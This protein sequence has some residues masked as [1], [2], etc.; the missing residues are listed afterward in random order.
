MTQKA[1]PDAF[2]R[3]Y[4]QRRIVKWGECD[5]FGIVY[6]P[7]ILD[8]A[9]EAAEGW[10]RDVVGVPWSALNAERRMGSPT[11]H[12]AI[13]FLRPVVC[14]QSLALKLRVTEL[15]RST[16]VFQIAGD[17][18]ASAAVSH[19]RV[20]LK[21]CLIDLTRLRPVAM[22]DDFRARILAFH[23]RRPPRR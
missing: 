20:R 15:G 7:R 11:V 9:L 23:G 17:S 18:G 6:T 22:P 13:D 14:D 21:I 2:P 1:T 5:P 19:F 3:A 16:V 8:Y 10:Y 12:A 4:V